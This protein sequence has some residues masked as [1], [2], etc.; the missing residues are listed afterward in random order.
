MCYPGN[1]VI[2][3]ILARWQCTMHNSHP[4]SPSSSYHL[5]TSHSATTSQFRRARA[6]GACGGLLES[7]RARTVAVFS[8]GEANIKARATFATDLAAG[9]CHTHWT[10]GGLA[11]FTGVNFPPTQKRGS[12]GRDVLL[13]DRLTSLLGL[14][15]TSSVFFARVCGCFC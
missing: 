14:A 11:F 2:V 1:T 15:L 7:R 13:R 8:F 6:W 5:V 3:L 4:T 12:I 10:H 9:R